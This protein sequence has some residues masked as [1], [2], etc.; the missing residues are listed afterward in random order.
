M[1]TK[2]ERVRSLGSQFSVV[3]VFVCSSFDANDGNLNR[4]KSEDCVE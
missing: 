1:D 4:K 2:R 3:H